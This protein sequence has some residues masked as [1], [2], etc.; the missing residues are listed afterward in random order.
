MNKEQVCRILV[1]DDEVE[2][3]RAL[4]DALAD[5][6][7]E[8]TGASDPFVAL[9]GIQPG[10]FDVLIIDLL[11]PGLDGIPLLK[12]AQD[13]DPDMIAIVMTG[14]ASV[15]S[16]REAAAAGAVAYLAK[17]FKIAALVS[18]V[19][20]AMNSRSWRFAVAIH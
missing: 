17:P 8:V 19:E 7:Y 20:R 9:E 4:C 5:Q 2:L 12:E 13:I 10:C 18:V 11:M 3:M 14:E 16:L 15:E 1:V 6:G